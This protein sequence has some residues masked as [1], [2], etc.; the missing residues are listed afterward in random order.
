MKLLKIRIRRSNEAGCT[1]YEYPSFY[2]ATK[3]VFGPVYESGVDETA[4]EAQ[5]R[6]ADDE[7]IIIGVKDEDVVQFLQSNNETKFGHKF[8]T[9]AISR[10]EAVAHGSK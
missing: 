2:D 9:V 7:F 1:H 10:D 3:V 6:D 4:K 5:D 8:D